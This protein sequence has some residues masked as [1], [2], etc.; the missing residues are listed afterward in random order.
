[1][2]G[3]T[4]PK[5][6]KTTRRIPTAEISKVSSNV[7]DLDSASDSAPDSASDP[8]SDPAVDSAS[9]SD[10]DVGN[11]S[12][13]APKR[14]ERALPSHLSYR[15]IPSPGPNWHEGDHGVAVIKSPIPSLPKPLALQ[16]VNYNRYYSKYVFQAST[17]NPPSYFEKLTIAD[18][19]VSALLA[20]YFDADK[21]EVV[22]RYG[23]TYKI[24]MGVPVEG[25]QYYFVLRKDPQPGEDE[26]CAIV[27]IVTAPPFT[28]QHARTTPTPLRIDR[29]YLQPDGN[30]H[31]EIND[32]VEAKKCSVVLLTGS[33]PPDKPFFEFYQFGTGS[34]PDSTLRP[35]FAQLQG[36][37][38]T[39]STNIFSLE[40]DEA[41]KVDEMF[42]A[43]V[44]GS[45]KDA[46]VTPD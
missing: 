18:R 28:K 13:R 24:V 21:F 37:E 40:T 16:Y 38:E 3:N 33:V 43:I 4:V 8:A 41:G 5:R 12:G 22:K 6:K 30:L 2:P 1:M 23:K 32:E 27:V 19:L 36:M 35:W 34:S 15:D 14:I 44:G 20:H 11:D 10:A 25:T 42:R 26:I 7:D 9:D 45:E 29:R 17:R 31:I 46:T 39:A